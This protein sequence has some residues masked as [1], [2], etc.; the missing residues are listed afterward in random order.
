MRVAPSDAPLGRKTA[1]LARCPP[2]LPQTRYSPG[3]AVFA[4]ALLPAVLAVARA[5]VFAL[6]LQPAVLAVARAVMQEIR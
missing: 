3:A 4:L 6:V 1:L 5:A 2:P